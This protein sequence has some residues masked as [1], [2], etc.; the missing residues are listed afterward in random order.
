MFV[1]GRR[2]LLKI[3][4]FCF[5]S[6]LWRDS[7][8]YALTRFD[9]NYT[10]YRLT[11]QSCRCISAY[12]I[13]GESEDAQRAILYLNGQRSWTFWTNKTI[14]CLAF[15]KEDRCFSFDRLGDRN[16]DFVAVGNFIN[17]QEKRFSEFESFNLDYFK[18]ELTWSKTSGLI[19]IFSKVWRTYAKPCSRKDTIRLLVWSDCKKPLSWETASKHVQ[20]MKKEH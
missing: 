3:F 1:L 15:F 9:S 8:Q 4:L 16:E 18:L 7:I 20:N 5:I 10:V 14:I 17:S 12:Q 19:T 13:Q 6:M 11:C 2:N